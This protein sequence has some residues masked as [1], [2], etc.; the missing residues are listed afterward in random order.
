MFRGDIEQIDERQRTP[1]DSVHGPG[2][3]ALLRLCCDS[4]IATPCCSAFESG[5]IL[6]TVPLLARCSRMI[7]ST[8]RGDSGTGLLLEAALLLLRR[9]LLR[10]RLKKLFVLRAVVACVLLVVVD[11]AGGGGGADAVSVGTGIDAC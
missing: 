3:E 1:S 10:K 6:C 11:T 9:L 7:A 5:A 4:P 8:V 2:R